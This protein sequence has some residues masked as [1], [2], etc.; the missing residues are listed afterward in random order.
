M[1]PKHPIPH[2]FLIVTGSGTRA[3]ARTL[4]IAKD[5]VTDALRSIEVL[6]WYVNYDYLNSHRNDAIT[7]EFVSVNEAE[8]GSFVGDQSH[9]FWRVLDH[10]TGISFRHTGT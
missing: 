8:M 4:R 7:V 9:Q 3:T 6:L 5:T 2:I 1:R 10:N